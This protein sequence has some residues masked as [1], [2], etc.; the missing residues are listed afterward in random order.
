MEAA[1]RSLLLALLATAALQSVARAQASEVSGIGASGLQGTDRV[2]LPTAE[3]VDATIAVSGSYGLTESQ[4]TDDGSHHRLGGRLAIGVAPWREFGFALEL[5]G[6]H[7]LH[8]D[9]SM[10]SDSGTVGDMHVRVRAGS[11]LVDGLA[12]GGELS[13]WLGSIDG[14]AVDFATPEAKLLLAWSDP[15]GGLTVAGHGGFRFDSSGDAA[16]DARSLRRGDRL[17]LGV[18]DFHAV[19]IGAAIGHRAGD[20]ELF[21]E[22]TWDLLVGSGAPTALESPIRAG[23]GGRFHASHSLQFEAMFGGS[24]S[25]RPDLGPDAPNVP[26]EPRV[27]ASLGIR[28]LIGASPPQVVAGD[29]PTTSPLNPAATS[30][31]AA[32]VRGQLLGP[33]G[34]PMAGAIIELTT[35]EQERTATT[36]AD[37]GYA[38]EEVPFG[39]A[40][41]RTA[42]DGFEPHTWKIDVGP[43]LAP[44]PNETLA[45]AKRRGLLQGLARSF[46]SR[47]VRA[48]IRVMRVDKAEKEGEAVP[49]PIELVADADGRFEVELPGGTYEVS[50][51]ADGYQPQLK[52][53]TIADDRV[54][55]LN[56]DLRRAK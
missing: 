5:D 46:G 54:E 44:L 24:P 1:L 50:V 16:P 53:I 2:L 41:L 30:E 38:F 33:D 11:D 20:L 27:G 18:S 6:R 14:A 36:G 25:A 4:G 10:G 51:T 12:L 13:V 19:L 28:Y 32:T 37:G 9:D 39:P 42:T 15:S 17:V 7:D 47:P 8:P 43:N 52:K 48:T 29:A 31:V 23:L 26:I 55:I 3:P 34:K 21:G 45:A 22:V 49:A 56:L 40:E 35:G